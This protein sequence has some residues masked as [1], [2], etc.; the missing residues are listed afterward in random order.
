M[1]KTISVLLVGVGG[2]G[3]V[4]A[5]DVLC[6][7]A[8]HAGF[9]VKKSE[10]HGMAQRGGSVVSHVRF[11]NKVFSPVIPLYGADY[12]MSFEQMEFLRY[13]SYPSDKPALI[14]NK[15]RI[16]PPSVA[17]GTDAYP[18]DIIS[19]YAAKFT[20][21]DEI[22][23]D[24]VAAAAGNAKAA[25]TVMLGTLSK[26]LKFDEASWDKALADNVPA[27]MLDVNI[28]AFRMGREL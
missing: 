27:K 25:G 9:D 8:M 28:K 10:I 20:E 14:L 1:N 22:D 21:C 12:V 6:A 17:S 7:A 18:V 16:L 13:M 5:S 23:A 15:R 4:L 24:A 26:Y 2:Q 11:G 19:K 3:I